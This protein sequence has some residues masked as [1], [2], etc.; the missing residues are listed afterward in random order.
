MFEYRRSGRSADAPTTESLPGSRRFPSRVGE[1]LWLQ[2]AAGNRALCD[3]LQREESDPALQRFVVLSSKLDPQPV[4]NR[5]DPVGWIY[6][7]GRWVLFDATRWPRDP[8]YQGWIR[9]GWNEPE[10]HPQARREPGTEP[11][12]ETNT[13][14]LSNVLSQTGAAGVAVP[15][16][17]LI[18]E[19]VTPQD[20]EGVLKEI[21]AWREYVNVALG[22]NPTSSEVVFQLQSS[23][24][25][26]TT[27]ADNLNSL[28]EYE[29]DDHD[30][31]VA[32]SADRIEAIVDSVYKK[33]SRTFTIENIATNP[34]NLYTIRSEQSP[35]VRGAGQALIR[36]IVRLAVEKG[37]EYVRVIALTEDH[38]TKYAAQG[39]EVEDDTMEESDTPRS[40]I[41]M[42]APV[43]TLRRRYRI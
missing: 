22:E 4:E 28:V 25:V 5:E 29:D 15:Q 41:P 30:F 2:T 1:L 11:R 19:Q 35:Q 17:P 18:I 3:V 23:E 36:N 39:F 13:A 42:R 37:S 8:D 43:E 38:V 9:T 10:D 40:E 27:I 20:G 26:L 7:F 21:N 34:R 14:R 33:R 12:G 6:V 32:K 31:D 16:K 24:R